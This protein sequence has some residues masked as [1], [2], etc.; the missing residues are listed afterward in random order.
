MDDRHLKNKSFHGY[1]QLGYIKKFA[2]ENTL[3]GRIGPSGYQ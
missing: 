3:A 1:C 2:K